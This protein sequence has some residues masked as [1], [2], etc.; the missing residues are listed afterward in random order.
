MT[1][2]VQKRSHAFLDVEHRRRKAQKIL[3]ILGGAGSLQGRTVLEIGVGSGVI[4]STLAEAVGPS[5]QIVAVDVVDERVATD[6]YEFVR[7]AG[8]ELPFEDGF[9]DVVVSNHV[10]EHVGERTD[11]IIHLSEIARVL[12]SDG[13]GYLAVPNRWRLIEPHFNLW[14][15]SWLPRALRSPYVRMAGKGSHYDCNP[16]GPLALR[17]ML[18]RAG[19]SGRDCTADALRAIA[20]TEGSPAVLR[21]LG[22]LPRGLIGLLSPLVPTMIFL[23]E[24]GSSEHR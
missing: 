6:G 19:L 5:G 21:G 2:P 22:L 24:K 3:H 20:A 23:L 7:V 13:T 15:L 12:S 14:L 8:A 1:V 4:S 16:P 17:A 11:Q 9:F 10:M 18:R